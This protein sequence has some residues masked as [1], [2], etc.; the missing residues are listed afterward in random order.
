MVMLHCALQQVVSTGE[1][2]GHVWVGCAPQYPLHCSVTGTGAGC[3]CLVLR[4]RGQSERETG[5][6]ERERKGDMTQDIRPHGQERGGC[7]HM[8]Y[9]PVRRFLFF[10][11]PVSSVFRMVGDDFARVVATRKDKGRRNEDEAVL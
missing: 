2:N 1:A 11:R 6:S 8:A 7:C 3:P 5:V 9:F 4:C 10:S